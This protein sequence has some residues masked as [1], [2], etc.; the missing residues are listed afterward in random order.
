MKMNKKQQSQLKSL[1]KP[2]RKVAMAELLPNI[3]FALIIIA[4]LELFI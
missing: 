3:A 2:V 1:L 4:L